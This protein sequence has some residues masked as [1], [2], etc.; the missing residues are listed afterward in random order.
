[1][2]LFSSWMADAR[3][4]AALEVAPGWVTALAG[5]ASSRGA[6][7]SAAASEP[8]PPGAVTASLTAPNVAD[9]AAVLDALR[10][11]LAAIDRRPKRVALVIPDLAARVSLVSFAQVPARRDDLE[12]LIRWQVRRAAPFPIDEA[13]VGYTA[14]GQDGDGEQTFAVVLAR[15]AIVREYEDLCAELGAQAGLVDIATLAALNVVLGAGRAV[16]GDWMVV[17]LRPE[18]TSLAI[19]RDERLLFLRTRAAAEGETVADLVHQTA[20]Y[21][22]DRLGGK[23]FAQV[24]LGGRGHDA[25]ALDEARRSVDARLGVVVDTMDPATEAALAETMAADGGLVEIAG[26][27]AGMLLRAEHEAVHA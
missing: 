9:R 21:Y 18:Y 23:E 6:W 15:R 7:V 3:L 14:L 17:H 10:A 24:F 2:S 20:M 16:Q 12:Q 22:H 4:D 19:M 1:M 25:S 27:A 11:A 13:A 5:S 26:P 8:L